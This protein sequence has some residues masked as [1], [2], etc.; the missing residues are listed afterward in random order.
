[1][2]VADDDL[3]SGIGSLNVNVANTLQVI[4]FTGNSSGFDVHFNRAPNL[5]DLN[6]YDGLDV[7][8]ELPDVTLVGNSVGNVMGSLVWHGATNTLSFVKTGGVLADETYTVTLFSDATAFHDA[9]GKLD[10]DSDFDDIESP[11]NYTHGLV[12]GT[13]VGT[14]TLSLHEI[15]R[16]LGQH[17][18][19]MWLCRCH[20]CGQH[21][22]PDERS[23]DSA[24]D[25]R[26]LC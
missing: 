20:A 11:D 5:A 21:R 9:F 12:I 3:L 4:A 8:V 18:D 10:G 15:A 26:H 25:L 19:D 2:Q 7:A 24:F 14:R 22:Q 23:I 1:M 16:G 13:A 6:L 17:I